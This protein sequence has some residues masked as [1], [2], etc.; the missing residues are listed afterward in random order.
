[1]QRKSE[2]KRTQK[3]IVFVWP[4]W[5]VSISAISWVPPKHVCFQ[6]DVHCSVQECQ[7]SIFQLSSKVCSEQMPK[8]QPLLLQTQWPLR[9]VVSYGNII[10]SFDD[11]LCCQSIKLIL[12]QEHKRVSICVKPEDYFRS[13]QR[14]FDTC[15]LLWL[16]LRGVQ[17]GNLWQYHLGRPICKIHCHL[18]LNDCSWLQR[19]SEFLTGQSHEKYCLTAQVSFPIIW[20]RN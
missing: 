15:P 16:T 5:S 8:P 6:C 13:L 7:L 4:L 19:Q 10:R 11:H 1:M 9:S 3:S 20:S 2:E 12:W 18:T 14:P 17:F